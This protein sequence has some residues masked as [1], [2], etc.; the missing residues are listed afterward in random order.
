MKP[1]LRKFLLNILQGVLIILFSVLLSSYYL[2]RNEKSDKLDKTVSKDYVDDANK[3]QDNVF[4]E[5]VVNQT[6][7]HEKIETALNKKLDADEFEKWWIKF[8]KTLNVMD[9][10][11]YE[12]WTVKNSGL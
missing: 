8:E 7:A 2:T 3:A 5:M 11:I 1:G 9:G 12:L 6:S 4:K 10:R